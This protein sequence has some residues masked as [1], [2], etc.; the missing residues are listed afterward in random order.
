MDAFALAVED[1]NDGKAE[2]L[3]QIQRPEQAEVLVLPAVVHV[4]HLIVGM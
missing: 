1:N 3:G 2:T 4:H